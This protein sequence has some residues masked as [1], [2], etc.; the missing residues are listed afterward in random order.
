MVD[1]LMIIYR[2]LITPQKRLIHLLK[3]HILTILQL[4]LQVL[5]M[6][7]LIRYSGRDISKPL[8]QVLIHFIQR[9]MTV[10]GYGLAQN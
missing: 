4:L 1:I 5:I 2:F 10:V 6:V 9:V 7:R 8:K 3:V